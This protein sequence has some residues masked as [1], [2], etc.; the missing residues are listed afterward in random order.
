[1]SSSMQVNHLAENIRHSNRVTFLTSVFKKGLKSKLNNLVEGY[2]TVRDGEESFSFGDSKSDFKAKVDIHSQEF[3]T[4]TGSGGALGIA[5]AYILGFWSADD[6]VVLMRILL[7]NRS[8][9][10][11]INNGL[12][13]ILNPINRIIHKSRQNTLSGSKD[14]I[15]AHYDLSNKFYEL[16]L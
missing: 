4:M 16:W 8:I 5:E 6:V 10:L 2:I 7:K 9:L 3:Y 14:N 15:L 1:M 13:K 11:S 12:A